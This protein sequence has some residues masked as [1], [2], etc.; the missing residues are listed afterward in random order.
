[1]TLS[2][3]LAKHAVQ[4]VDLLQIDAEG[5]DYE[6]LKTIDFREI[7]PKI[8]RFEHAHL[9]P[10]EK[11]ECIELLISQDYRVVTG[12]HDMTAFQSRWMSPTTFWSCRR[13][14]QDRPIIRSSTSPGTRLP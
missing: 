10:A 1:M 4:T 3:L 9:G 2:S 14:S 12:A 11:G 7:K 6:I 13:S 5:Y 8:I